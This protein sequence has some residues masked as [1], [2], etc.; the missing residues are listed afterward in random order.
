MGAVPGVKA[1]LTDASC[2]PD[3]ILAGEELSART[4]S[5]Q[6]QSL[7]SSYLVSHA[8]LIL[9][10]YQSISSSEKLGATALPLSR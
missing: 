2:M 10:I 8:F 7:A 5:D 9:S 6:E 1:D 4:Q 3:I